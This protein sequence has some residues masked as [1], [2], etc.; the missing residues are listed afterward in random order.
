MQRPGVDQLLFL[1][2]TQVYLIADTHE[3]A[4]LSCLSVEAS[5]LYNLSK[6]LGESLVLQD[7]R[8][9]FKVVGSVMW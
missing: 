3:T 1:S 4:P 6:L 8:P 5:D 9:G 7:P 2:S